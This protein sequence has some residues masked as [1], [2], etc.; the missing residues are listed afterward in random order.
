M[1]SQSDKHRCYTI[2]KSQEK[3]DSPSSKSVYWMLDLIDTL[4]RE[5]RHRD[6]LISQL[7]KQVNELKKKLSEFKDSVIEFLVRM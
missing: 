7:Q 4:D 1:I 2:K 3:G 6:S 5:I